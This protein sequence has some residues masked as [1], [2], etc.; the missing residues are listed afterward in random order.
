M[1]RNYGLYQQADGSHGARNPG[2]GWRLHFDGQ[3]FTANPDDGGW[4]WGLELVGAG[5]GASQRLTPRAPGNHL[6]IRHTP[7]REEWFINDGRG[8]EQGWTLQEPPQGAE[9]SGV[10]RLEL[11]VRGSLT[12]RGEG[13][14]VAFEDERGAVVLNYG[15]LKA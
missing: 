12:A 6:S 5:R 1:R 15:G 9:E 4:E 3:G 2:Q 10:I 13:G 8:L 7:R 14:S 11:A